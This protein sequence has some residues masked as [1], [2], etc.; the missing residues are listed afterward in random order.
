[1]QRR[2]IGIAN[3]VSVTFCCTCCGGRRGICECIPCSSIWLH[4]G[5]LIT[6]SLCQSRSQPGRVPDIIA[7]TFG[8]CLL[9]LHSLSAIRWHW[10][11]DLDHSCCG[12]IMH[13]ATCWPSAVAWF[14]SYK[15]MAII[16][17]LRQANE[18]RAAAIGLTSWQLDTASTHYS[19]LSLCLCL[20]V[21][22]RVGH[23]SASNAKRFAW[24]RLT[25]KWSGRHGMSK[26]QHHWRGSCCGPSISP[27][28]AVTVHGTSSHL[29]GRESSLRCAGD[30]T[31]SE[32]GR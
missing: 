19:P 25:R 18:S 13:L 1:M 4:L 2:C 21:V 10:Q 17:T 28:M 31:A 5:W 9:P 22:G 26:V 27:S 16:Q 32:S 11:S 24:F 8:A 12:T 3:V 29:G 30:A 15:I 14:E 20:C 23:K 6:N 7:T